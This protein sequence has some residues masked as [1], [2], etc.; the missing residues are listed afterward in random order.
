MSSLLRLI[1]LLQWIEQT[2]K[3]ES[4]TFVPGAIVDYITVTNYFYTYVCLFAD[5]PP[6]ISLEDFV[7]PHLKSSS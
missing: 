4:H 2:F 6:L 7:W 5:A 1:E 3:G